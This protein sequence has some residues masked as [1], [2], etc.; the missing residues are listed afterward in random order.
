MITIHKLRNCF[1]LNFRNAKKCE[2]KINSLEKEQATLESNF[3]SMQAE[4]K[5]IEVRAAKLLQDIE[6]IEKEDNDED[7]SGNKLT[8]FYTLFLFGINNF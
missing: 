8:L 3:M 1:S 2:E 7:F 5:A 6:K 4:R